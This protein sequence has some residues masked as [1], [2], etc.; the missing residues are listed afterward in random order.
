MRDKVVFVGC[1]FTAG[2]G[3]LDVP[4]VE[5]RATECKDSPHLWVNICHREIARIK[6]LELVNIGQGGASNAEILQNAVRSISLIDDIDI[7]FCQWTS[8]PRY[9]FNV[10]FE[11]WNTS[12]AL[13]NTTARKHD[14]NLNKGDHWPRKYIN[15]LL[16]RML[17]LHH[18]H[19]E[20]LKIVDYSSIL[21]NLAK[22]R[23][24]DI[25]FINGL[26]PWD[27]NYFTRLENV[28]PE[29]YTPFTK[30]EIL[31]IESRDDE[32]IFKLY[33]LAHDQYQKAGGINEHKWVNLYNSFLK[34][35]IDVNF[36]LDH[37][38]K[39]SN[40]IFYNLVKQ[41]LENIN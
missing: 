12:E 19:W 9:N 18:L 27:E 29:S 7:M 34:N 33:N 41:K 10:G 37:P 25:F 23:G 5:S 15:D 31:N 20:I 2:I 39:Q 22:Q 40:F 13:H 21:S 28:K 14:V 26:C 6:D 35:K 11:L 17:V 16:D 8:V 24:F 36:D 1:S 32:D 30:K 4:V 38:G 3:W